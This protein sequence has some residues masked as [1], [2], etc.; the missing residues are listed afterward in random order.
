MN[1]TSIYTWKKAVDEQQ[2][3]ASER[4]QENNAR[5][6][7]LRKNAK[8]TVQKMCAERTPK[9]NV[10]DDYEVIAHGMGA[11]ND[12]EDGEYVVISITGL[13]QTKK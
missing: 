8:D 1:W 3:R 10:L 7:E 9:K 5:V 6:A 2:H 12:E 13:C 4:Q 11:V